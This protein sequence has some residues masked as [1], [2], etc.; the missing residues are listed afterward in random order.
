MRVT[1][2]VPA[3]NEEAT[4][5][6]VVAAVPEDVVQRV[7]VVNNGSSD[8]TAEV[9]KAAGAD[10]I[11]EPRRGYGA[12]CHA[13]AQAA[14]DADVLVFLDGDGA[15]DPRQ[16][17]RLVDPILDDD[18]DLVLGSRER[19]E[20][21]A[22][23]LLP[24]AR[25]GNWLAARLMRLLFGLHVTDLGPFRAI[26]QRVLTS[27]NMR[28]MTYGWPTE[29]MVKA[30]KGGYRVLEVPVS[31][32]RRAG[33][34]SKISGTLRGTVLAAYHILGTTLKYAVVEPE[35]GGG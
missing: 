10:V 2:I 32:R 21:E 30:A 28:E 7:I 13:G 34:E 20:R 29:M 3:L 35:V 14:A 17:P 11:H 8:A 26:R 18:A 25:L 1:A 33:G 16:I 15:D 19:G 23:A 27:L 6:D 31:Y 5:V 24:H 9:A 22:G 4:I 12:A